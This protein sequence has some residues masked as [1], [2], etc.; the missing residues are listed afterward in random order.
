LDIKNC[1]FFISVELKL[2]KISN[3]K[4]DFK[5]SISEFLVGFYCKD[6][7]QCHIWE[8]FYNENLK[9]ETIFLYHLEKTHSEFELFKDIDMTEWC[10]YQLNRFL[11]QEISIDVVKEYI[12]FNKTEFF[13]KVMLITIFLTFLVFFLLL[14]SYFQ[15]E[16]KF[17]N[18]F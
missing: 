14:S 5:D 4:K 17:I 7:Q 1:I 9:K 10:I 15:I 8:I 6:N 16:I 11:N 18:H 12:V 2:V 13:L 3:I